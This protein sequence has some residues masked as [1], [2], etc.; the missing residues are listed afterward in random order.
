MKKLLL[1]TLTSAL[2]LIAGTT[3]AFAMGH[4]NRAYHNN[5]DYYQ[6]VN[7]NNCSGLNFADENGDGICDYQGAGQYYIDENDDGVCDNYGTNYNNYGKHK[8]GGRHHR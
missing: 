4:G 2:V 1:L 6:G 3:S 8:A 5:G 7:H